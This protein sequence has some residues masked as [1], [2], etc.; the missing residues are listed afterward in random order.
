MHETVAVL[1][2]AAA[3]VLA[4]WG[5]FYGFVLDRAERALVKRG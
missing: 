4:Y 3:G 5:V 1:A 2:L